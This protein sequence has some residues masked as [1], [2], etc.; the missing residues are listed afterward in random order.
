IS[1]SDASIFID[2]EEVASYTN[3]DLGTVYVDLDVGDHDIVT[4]LANGW[5]TVEYN[6]TLTEQPQLSARQ[7]AFCMADA[8]ANVD[9]VVYASGYAPDDRYNV[10]KVTIAPRSETIFVVLSAYETT[11]WVIDNPHGVNIAGI[12]YDSFDPG[13]TVTADPSIPQFSI[14]NIPF[15]LKTLD[16]AYAYAYCQEHNYCPVDSTVEYASCFIENLF[17]KAPSSTVYSY[18]FETPTL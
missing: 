17:G 3:Q 12:A 13:S 14:E 2:G 16:E 7:A 1:W 15:A 5:H 9:A 11:H 10:E 8:L 18:Y 6:L 4:T